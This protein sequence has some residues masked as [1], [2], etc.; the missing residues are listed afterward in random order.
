MSFLSFLFP[1]QP[2]TASDWNQDQREALVDLLYLSIYVDNHISLLEEKKVEEELKRA[3]WDGP[4]SSIL[5][6]QDAVTRGRNAKSDPA[7]KA[8]YLN[9]IAN[10][11]DEKKTAALKALDKVLSSDGTDSKEASFLKEVAAA[12]KL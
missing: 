3:D 6:V 2:E 1:A 12:F 7:Y 10:R 9:S 4:T 5:Y 8:E 11:L